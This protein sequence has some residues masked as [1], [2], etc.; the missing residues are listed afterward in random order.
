MNQFDQSHYRFLRRDPFPLVK[1]SNSTVR[2]DHAVFWVSVAAAI[3]LVML[4]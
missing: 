4:P 1:F 3:L 2:G